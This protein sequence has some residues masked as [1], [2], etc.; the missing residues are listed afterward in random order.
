[1][2]ASYVCLYI[3]A[4]ALSGEV[5]RL[6]RFEDDYIVD[7]DSAG[8]THFTLVRLSSSIIACT[9]GLSQFARWVERDGDLY[10]VRRMII[11]KG[12]NESISLATVRDS[13]TEAPREGV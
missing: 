11:R 5:V 10:R 1:M 13:I 4:P 6:M 8:I 2:S 12:A 7:T 3:C 9:H